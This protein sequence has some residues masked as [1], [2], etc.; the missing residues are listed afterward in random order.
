MVEASGESILTYSYTWSNGRMSSD[1]L[2]ATCQSSRT[3]ESSNLAPLEAHSIMLPS[4][5]GLKGC[6]Y[7]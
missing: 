4:A 3:V 1:S 2:R 5:N 6:I 7:I